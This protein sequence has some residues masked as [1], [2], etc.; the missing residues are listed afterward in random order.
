MT[1]EGGD[2]NLQ[3]LLVEEGVLLVEIG[4]RDDDLIHAGV[5]EEDEELRLHLVRLHHVVVGWVDLMP[6]VLLVV[7]H[8]FIFSMHGSTQLRSYLEG[9]AMLPKAYRLCLPGPPG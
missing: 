4:D 8:I 2:F 5:P 1:D 6:L 3:V 7:R 9:A